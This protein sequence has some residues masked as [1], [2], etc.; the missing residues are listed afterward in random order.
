MLNQGDYVRALLWS[1]MAREPES[2]E[3]INNHY[4]LQDLVQGLAM[5]MLTVPHSRWSKS[6]QKITAP[7][8]WIVDQQKVAKIDC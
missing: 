1:A 4:S 6:V 3:G 2:R 7:S 5:L 8:K